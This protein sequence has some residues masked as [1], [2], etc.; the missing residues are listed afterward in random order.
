MKKRPLKLIFEILG[1]F[2]YVNRTVE[3]NGIYKACT[4]KFM[5]PLPEVVS[6]FVPVP[7]DDDTAG[8]QAQEVLHV[9]LTLK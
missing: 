4:L 5:P 3:Q 1:L 9:V 2:E 7:E 6:D 8:G